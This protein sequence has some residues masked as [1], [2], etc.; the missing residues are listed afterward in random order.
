MRG[1]R[2]RSIWRTFGLAFAIVLTPALMQTEATCTELAGET[3][4]EVFRV[5]VGG[6][7]MIAFDPDTRSYEVTLPQ[8]QETI[9][10]RAIPMDEAAEVSYRL[11]EICDPRPELTTLAK[12]GEG[13]FVLEAPEGH[14]TLQVWV[15]SPD[16]AMHEYTVLFIQPRQ[17]E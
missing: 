14:S 4:L 8:E 2:S 1:S 7:E 11:S 17:C 3:R 12:T 9:W 16:G 5:A 13:V 10:V 15:H 6:E